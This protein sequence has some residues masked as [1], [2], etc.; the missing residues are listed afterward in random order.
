MSRVTDAQTPEVAGPPAGESAADRWLTPEVVER[1]RLTES[2]LDLCE[3]RPVVRVIAA[4][5]VGKTTAVAQAL[6]AIDRPLAWLSLDEWHSTPGR[7]ADDLVD[8]VAPHV[9]GLAEEMRRLREEGAGAVYLARAVGSLARRR[10]VVLV[11]DDCHA[12]RRDDET[13]AA[14]AS[15]VRAGDPGMCVV[16]VGRAELPLRTLGLAAHDPAALIGDGD[17]RA[18]EDEAREIL[19]SRG[20]DGD[21]SGPVTAADG[22]VAGLVIA[23]WL[24]GARLTSP[25][26]QQYLRDDV[27]SRLDR[28]A[29][30]LL[31]AASIHDDVTSVRAEDLGVP[32]VAAWFETLRAAGI[33]AEWDP[34]GTTM[35]LHP[36]V[37]ESL[38]AELRAGAP[39]RLRWA[40][41]AAG[42]SL[43]RE[44]DRERAAL[45]YVEA[46][47][48]QD[49]ARILPDVVRMSLDRHDL[50]QAAR[51]LDAG[52][53]GADSADLVLARLEL[54]SLRASAAEGCRIIDALGRNHLA[55]LVRQEPPIGALACHFLAAN[56]RIDEAIA[57]AEGM[58]PGR[59]GDVARLVL[60]LIRDDPDCALPPFRGDPLDASIGRLLWARGRLEELREGGTEWVAATGVGKLTDG[61]GAPEAGITS[62]F[63]RT[64]V[65]FS[66]AVV[67][68]DLAGARA[69]VSELGDHG[70]ST[71]RLLCEIELAVRL[72]R[73]PRKALSAI[74]ALR[75]TDVVGLAFYRELIS[76][77]EGAALLLAGEP[78]AGAVSVLEEAVASMRRGDRTLALSPALVYLAEGHWRNGD[79]TAADAA[80][81]DAYDVARRQ[82]SMRGL[83]L[84]FMDFPGVLSRHLDAEPHEHGAWHS[85]AR[86]LVSGGGGR[87]PSVPPVAFLREFGDPALVVD[88]IAVRPR[89][90]K[91]LELVAYLVHSPA[92]RVRRT[93][94]LD[95]LWNGR[96][97][98]QSR[99]YL[100]QALRHLREV[101]PDGIA[102]ASSDDVLSLEGAFSSESAAFEAELAE[103]AAQ[104]PPRR[105]SMI[106]AA[107]GTA[108]R[109]VFL[110][111]SVGV[112]WIDER[113]AHLEAKMSGARLDAAELMLDT[114]RHIEALDLLDAAME[115]DP[116]LER[117]WQLRMRAHGLL[118]DGDG[119]LA[120]YR[121]CVTELARIGL[122]PSRRTTEIART[123][124]R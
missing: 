76:T 120:A 48:R 121:G 102:V 9:P 113:R 78:A 46:H 29:D 117:G 90:R 122:E 71:W 12:I 98:Q 27:R 43:E 83:L 64:V 3:S 66:Q 40:A 101:L 73:D 67:R 58:P 103:A 47:S 63:A 94:L 44:G 59:A 80:T 18:T 93:E 2:I 65:A 32:D 22:W 81:R 68:R 13:V 24:R 118:G 57:L 11:L 123:F 107:L 61:A 84:A 119:V 74:G 37:R 112:A 15:L 109:G 26:L 20:V 5:G 72:E 60:S 69:A 19:A 53:D 115:A 51:F 39:E 106:L 14:V 70:P 100:R 92:G 49:L 108:Q 6:G 50:D 1:A 4:A 34:D 31:V 23:A 30:E 41:C 33:P 21:L 97:D 105:L 86:A 95:A 82:G 56:G 85:L 17:L 77:W 28:S 36:A 111:G 116:L 96:D 88:G 89:I 110:A 10:R 79:E 62:Q 87:S 124:R 55:S 114:G 35:R 7:F 38:R 8:T 54:A 99:G 75:D 16:L 52:G 25:S 104:D 42:R 91:S 45:L